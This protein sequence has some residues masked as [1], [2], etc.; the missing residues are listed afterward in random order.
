MIG[1]RALKSIY[2]DVFSLLLVLTLVSPLAFDITSA[3][4]ADPEISD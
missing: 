4:A 1:W 3:F 2:M